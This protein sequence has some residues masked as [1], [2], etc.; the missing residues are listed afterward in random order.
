M[1]NELKILR[2]KKFFKILIEERFEI[3]NDDEFLKALAEVYKTESIDNSEKI[4]MLKSQIE[5]GQYQVDETELIE[6]ILTQIAPE[7]A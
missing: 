6:K 7:D 2:K 4:Q 3:S 1:Q 5:S